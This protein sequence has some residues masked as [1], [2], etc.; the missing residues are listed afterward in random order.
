M[1]MWMY[2]AA[3]FP[4]DHPGQ[5]ATVVHS[6]MST[7]SPPV[8][9]AFVMP[10][11]EDVTQ[12]SKVLERQLWVGR[13]CVCSPGTT[14]AACVYLQD[15]LGF[16]RA[17]FA[18]CFPPCIYKYSLTGSIRVWLMT[19][20]LYFCLL[21]CRTFICLF[22]SFSLLPGYMSSACRACSIHPVRWNGIASPTLLNA[23]Q[24]T[25]LTAWQCTLLTAWQRTLLTAWQCSTSIYMA[26][27]WRTSVVS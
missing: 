13:T 20:H 24:C 2:S 16:L 5:M 8:A 6:S 27:M 14:P 17:S 7:S 4:G 10:Q 15:A 1:A 23:W 9:C 3:L 11:N 19:E 22:V 18:R 21:C 12:C 25:L 26:L